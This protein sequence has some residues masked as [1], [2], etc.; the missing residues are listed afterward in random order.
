MDFEDTIKK[1]GN[2]RGIILPITIWKAL[3]FNIGDKVIVTVDNNRL[4]ITKK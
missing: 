3:N 1:I 4:I 2:S